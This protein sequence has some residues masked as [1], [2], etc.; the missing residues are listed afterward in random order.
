MSPGSGTVEPV[1][2]YG[3]MV[4]GVCSSDMLGAAVAE[5]RQSSVVD[6]TDASFGE[7]SGSLS[8]EG[9]QRPRASS[10]GQSQACGIGAKLAALGPLSPRMGPRQALAQWDS[11]TVEL[12]PVA[13]AARLGAALCSSPQVHQSSSPP[14]HHQMLI[15]PN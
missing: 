8:V 12:R 6:A 4:W 11:G 5:S 7:T 9:R 1:V 3:I 13:W 14:P 15:A 10:T 2:G